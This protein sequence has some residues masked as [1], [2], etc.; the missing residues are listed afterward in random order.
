MF[1]EFEKSPSMHCFVAYSTIMNQFLKISLDFANTQ[2]ISSAST[3]GDSIPG[4][5]NFG[6]TNLKTHYPFLFLTGV[7][8]SAVS[9]ER[10]Y[11]TVVYSLLDLTVK[12]FI[13]LS[14]TSTQSSELLSLAT[15]L[16]TIGKIQTGKVYPSPEENL[17]PL[18][19][20]VKRRELQG[21]CKYL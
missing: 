16:R 13:R 9:F 2:K 3:I 4:I 18:K 21:T 17:N 8:I 10:I 20:T 1:D 12:G 6:A 11:Y 5:M 15:A 14:S 19:P 7:N